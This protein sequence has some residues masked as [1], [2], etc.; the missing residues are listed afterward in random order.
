MR[1]ITDGT[2]NTFVLGERV[3]GAVVLGRNRQPWPGVPP[4]MSKA[5]GGAWGDL[6]IGEHWP[7]G[8]PQ[9]G[10]PFINGGPCIINC[11]NLRSRGHMSYHEGGAFFLM[12]DGAVRFI[13]ANIDAFTFAGLYTREKGEVVGEF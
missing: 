6:L 2:S 12:G 8:S 10:N 13:S 7:N 5:Q 3:G 4:E 9:D 11:S 1:D